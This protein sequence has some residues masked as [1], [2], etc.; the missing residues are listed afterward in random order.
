MLQRCDFPRQ[1]PQEAYAVDAVIT[2]MS[3]LTSLYLRG[4]HCTIATISRYRKPQLPSSS[5]EK[6]SKA[7][8]VFRMPPDPP[9]AEDFSEALAVTEWDSL[10][11]LDSWNSNTVNQEQAMSIAQARKIKLQIPPPLLL[12]GDR[13][14]TN[15]IQV[16][17]H[18][19]CLSFFIVIISTSPSPRHDAPRSNHPVTAWN[20][21][22]LSC[23]S[24]KGSEP[25][26]S[27]IR[28]LV[29]SFPDFII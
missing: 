24:F 14:Q 17:F 1:D 27:P 26:P 22:P 10:T 9:M 28:H 19:L 4:F 7:R 5:P 23:M 8:L 13:S 29:V 6:P 20:C 16:R 2:S 12:C 15:V 18:V 21:I 11:V 25:W 3:V